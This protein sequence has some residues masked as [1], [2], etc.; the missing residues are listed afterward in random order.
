MALFKALRCIV[1][2]MYV[3]HICFISSLA[4]TNENPHFWNSVHTSHVCL[5]L[6]VRTIQ[7]TFHISAKSQLVICLCTCTLCAL[8][9]NL[10]RVM[11]CIKDHIEETDV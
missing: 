6:Y 2:H 10:T 5:D 11:I 9:E 7:L 3:L 8:L 4:T 1:V